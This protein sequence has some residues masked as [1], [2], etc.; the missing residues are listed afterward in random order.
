MPHS[1]TIVTNGAFNNGACHTACSVWGAD[2]G[3]GGTTAEP[4]GTT[5]GEVSVGFGGE[6]VQN[7]SKC[8]KSSSY[9]K[10]T[11]VGGRER[12]KIT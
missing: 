11:E 1:I 2:A 9:K 5:V 6:L 8:F 7:R 12:E 10:Q 3:W 4:C